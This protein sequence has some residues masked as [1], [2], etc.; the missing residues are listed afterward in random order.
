MKNRFFHKS[1]SPDWKAF[2]SCIR[3]EG[4]PKRVHNIEIGL[5]EEIK[6][7]LCER[8]NLLDGLNARDPFFAQQR[9]IRVQ[10][11]LGY[12]YVV[13]KIDGA[14]FPLNWI[15]T[16]DTAQAR[17]A[18]GREYIDEHRGPVTNWREFEAYP[19]P[20][21]RNA[22]TRILEW[23]ERNLPEDMCVIGGLTG[24]FAEELSWLLGYETLCIAL[25]E[26]RDLVQAISDKLIAHYGQIGRQYLE[27]ERVKVIW[28]TDDMGFR[29]GT[30]MSPDDLRALVLPGHRMLAGLSHAAGRLYLLHSCGKLDEI[31]SD[32]VDQV[33]IDA[34]HSFEDT[35]ED[36]RDVKRQWGSRVALLGGLDLDFMCR[37]S[38]DEV[39]ARTRD[40]LA[41]CQPGGGYC[42]G[43]GNSVA[44]YIN[45]DNY[46][47][48]LDEGRRFA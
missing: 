32:L 5:D 19:W 33:G 28:G 42:L 31:M 38:E 3:R 23:Y 26:Q 14:N 36:V 37:A 34:K 27:F 41:K 44:N 7:A 4:T 21:P 11:F 20:D 16:E 48:M 2:V 43:T 8:F 18:E 13:G 46:L 10:R 17:K 22:D 29:S 45:I 9:E 12:D 40:T 1:V 25:F 39:R 35:I 30:M 47:A 24:H 6:T 15:K